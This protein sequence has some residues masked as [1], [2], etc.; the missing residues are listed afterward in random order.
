MRGTVLVTG[1]AGYIGSHTC[2]ALAHSGFTPVTF[3]NLSIGNRWAVRWGP[4]EIG[5]I[6]DI[7]RLGEVMRRHNPVGIVHFA[8]LALVGESMTEPALYYRQNVAG[9]LAVLEAAR[10]AGLPPFV[11]SSTC[12]V[13]GTSSEGC[14]DESLPTAPI[15][16]YGASK[17]MVERVL[18][19][20]GRAYGLRSAT[21]RY[22]NAAGADPDGEIGEFRAN[23]THLIPNA[24]E[25]LLGRKQA[26]QVFG[27]DYPTEDGTAIRDY[28]HVSDLALAHVRA[29]ERLIGGGDRFVCNLGTGS[30]ASVAHIVAM[31]ERLAN[32]KLPLEDAPRRPGDPPEL[33]ANPSL[34]KKLLGPDLTT[35]SDIETILRTALVWHQ[36]ERLAALAPSLQA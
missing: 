36:G 28:I 4:I 2:K 15:N 11:F 3:D 27:R 19:D 7:A 24:V 22:F 31:L 13:Y 20:Y 33:V 10:A 26:L 12:A 23:E 29:L 18:E 14:I 17:L 21:L 34:S 25:A 35:R 16:P 6:S 32:R 30:G 9:T 1:G 5:D 8:A